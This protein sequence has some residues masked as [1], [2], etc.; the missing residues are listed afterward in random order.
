MPLRKIVVRKTIRTAFLLLAA[1]HVASA[2]SL[3]VTLRLESSVQQKYPGTPVPLRLVAV[4]STPAEQRLPLNAFIHVS[5]LDEERFLGGTSTRWSR[6]ADGEEGPLPIAP[7]AT[8][9][10]ELSMSPNADTPSFLLDPFLFPPGRYTIRFLAAADE[11][12]LAD[13]ARG[14][15]TLS[16]VM[17]AMPDVTISTPLT[18]DVIEPQG[19][20]AEA[21]T[22]LLNATGGSGWR[23]RSAPLLAQELRSRYP[24]SQYT[25]IF[26]LTHFRAESLS[27]LEALATL[28]RAQNPRPLMLDWLDMTIAGRHASECLGHLRPPRN[29]AAAAAEC[30]AA[31]ALYASITQ[32]TTNA[33]ARTKAQESLVRTMNA[34]EVRDHA[35]VRDAVDAGTY[36]PLVPI[37]QCVRESGRRLEA[38]FGYRN[39][40]AF[41]VRIGPGAR[42]GFTPAPED[43]GQPT[44]FAPGLH[45]N[46]VKVVLEAKKNDA[47]RAIFW[48]LDGVTVSAPSD[49]PRCKGK[50]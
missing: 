46:A 40:N 5:R 39:P 16:S 30:E 48:T 50:P 33:D 49:A 17:Q 3:G 41:T 31:R 28:A 19:V 27:Q 1:A 26:G 37:L 2:Q 11:E 23:S 6:T 14:A 20:D 47:G 24:E 38:T 32:T 10:S 35:L 15:E 25:F 8:V 4:N 45:E 7:G 43:R 18:I 12:R 9:V 44:A 21:W 42:N 34:D 29:T 13:L 22:Y 36:V